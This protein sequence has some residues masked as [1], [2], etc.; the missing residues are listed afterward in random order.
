MT[1]V[2]VN[3]RW[4]GIRFGPKD[5]RLPYHLCQTCKAMDRNAVPEDGHALGPGVWTN[6]RGI[7]VWTPAER[8]LCGTD[9]GYRTHLARKEPTCAACRDAVRPSH[10][11]PRKA[12]LPCGTHA[13]FNRHKKGGEDPCTECQEAEHIYQSAR[14]RKPRTK[15]AA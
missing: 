15:V 10:Y 14:Q 5:F 9:A 7:A 8:P 13:A 2:L 1:N 3:C 11:G 12:H 4:C 6:V